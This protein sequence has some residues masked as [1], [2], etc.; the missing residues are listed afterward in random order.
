MRLALPSLPAVLSRSRSRL[1]MPHWGVHPEDHKRPAADAP[2]R[3][4]P[5]PKRLY[6]P[7]QQH[8]GQPARPIVVVGQ[9]VR[10]GQLIAQATGGSTAIANSYLQMRKAG[11]GE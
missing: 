4:L 5:L 10:R 1:R 3:R 2:V 8:V 6:L 7:L 11:L 9:T